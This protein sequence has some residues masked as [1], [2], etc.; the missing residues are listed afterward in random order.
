MTY[1]D[2]FFDLETKVALSAAEVIMPWILERTGAKTVVDIGCGT[3]AF[4]SVA[5]A[6][7]CE[8]SGYDG[9]APNDF[10]LI[11]LD[12]FHRQD[13]KAGVS[14]AG[15]DLAICLEVAEHLPQSSAQDLVSGLCD[16]DVVLWS[17]AIPGQNGV[18]HIN[19][20][21]SSWWEPYFT[22]CGYVGSCDIRRQLWDD[23]RI[24]GFYRQNLVV[25]ARPH[26]L[27]VMGMV[28]GVLDEIHPD[29]FIGF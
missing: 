21:W 6:N 16:A 24:A 28:P 10:L 11:T 25:W 15:F 13:L 14:C 27:G 20:Q 23:R 7:G 12:E 17:A 22:K 9:Y 8:V 1:N 5:K 29:R 3:G 2:A 18:D 19:E 4:L 26:S